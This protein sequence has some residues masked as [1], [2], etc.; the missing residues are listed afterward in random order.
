MVA[1][2]TLKR[3][4]KMFRI[5]KEFII[6]PLW[7]IPYKFKWSR[8]YIFYDFYPYY[9]HGWRHYFYWGAAPQ[10]I[11]KFIDHTKRAI[12]KSLS[13]NMQKKIMDRF[14]CC[15]GS[16]LLTY[17]YANMEVRNNSNNVKYFSL[18]RIIP[19][20]Y[21]IL[22]QTRWI[23]SKNEPTNI[24]YYNTFSLLGEEQE[25]LVKEKTTLFRG[26]VNNKRDLL[27][28]FKTYRTNYEG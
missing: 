27:R 26:W 18:R 6:E 28:L 14:L 21:Y 19:F 10:D 7:D 8:R 4:Y 20:N 11:S 3:H 24:F 16:K 12:H 2:K 25:K 5:L 13:T 23:N 22:T 1:Y 9:W 15:N 17:D